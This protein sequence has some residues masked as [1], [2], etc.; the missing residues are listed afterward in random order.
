MVCV[1]GSSLQVLKYH[2]HLFYSASEALDAIFFE[3]R[4]ADKCIEFYLKKNRKWG[5]RDRRFFAETVYDCVR[6]WRLYWFLLKREPQK[7]YLPLIAVSL[8]RRGFE[9]PLWDEFQKFDLEVWQRRFDKNQS[10]AVQESFPDWL[11][12][13]IKSE[14]SQWDELAPLFNKPNSLVLRP[15]T[16]KTNQ[17]ALIKELAKDDILAEPLEGTPA[18]VIIKKRA[19]VFR[20]DAFKKGL[21]EVQDGSSQLVAGYLEVEPG[22]RVID[23]CA[24]AGGKTL[25]IADLMDNRGKIISL[26]IHQWKLDQL[27]LRARRNT[28]SNIEMKCI[29]SSKTTKRLKGTADRL[30]LDVPCSGLGVLRRNPDTKWKL[31]QQNLDEL[32]KTQREILDQYS[33]MLKPGGKM[34]YATCSVL[35]SENEK[36]VEAFIE[37]NSLF[38]L[39]KHQTILPNKDGFDGFFMA[40]LE[41]LGE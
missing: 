14:I 3:D 12:E 33:S 41:K 40:L 35:P 11:Y 6:W 38:K 27:K 29:E 25:H 28:Y 24:G 32:L 10:P 36:Q 17:S 21:F 31:S 37:R 23:A 18:G 1:V 26:D 13:K 9:L 7:N 19:N 20:T 22:Q 4:Y 30:L 34:V 5:S 16:Q 15:N 39:T 2:K 8:W